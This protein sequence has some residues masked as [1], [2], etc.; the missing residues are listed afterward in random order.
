MCPIT[1]ISAATAISLTSLAVGTASAVA[2]GMA[3]AKQANAQAEYQAA[4]MAEHK[5]VNELNN[6]AAVKEFTEQS[7]AERM[8]QMQEQVAASAAAQDV[9]KEALQKK[10]TMMA[11]TNAAGLALDWL[12]ADYEREEAGRLDGIRQQYEMSSAN[13]QVVL[14]SYQDKT[15]N[16]L[17]GQSNFIAAPSSYS[18]GMNALGTALG[19]GSAAVGAYGTYK[20]YKD[21][22]LRENPKT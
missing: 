8:A 18:S 16:R 5:R 4:Q 10:G 6:Q 19:I 7:A 17:N 12:M 9:Q 13:S 21:L 11:S 14:Q 15:Q 1:G 2:S 3:Q 22:E 20:K